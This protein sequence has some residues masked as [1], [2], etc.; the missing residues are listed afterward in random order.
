MR[1][2]IAGSPFRHNERSFVDRLTILM[3][4]TSLVWMVSG[5]VIGA[6]MLSDRVV[7]GAWRF[8]MQPTHGHMLF[9]GWFVQFVIGIAYWLLPRKRTPELP[10]GYNETPALVGV[11][12]LNAGL[13][14]R[15]VGEPMDRIRGE[16]EVAMALLVLSSVL[17]LGA[18]LIFVWQMWPRIYGRDKMGD[19]RMKKTVEKIAKTQS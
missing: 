6:L 2:R 12:V 16:D 9:V 8:W 15:V 1:V 17:Q 3:V 11:A 10:I 18:I 4:K 14:L 13:L 7:P 5:F 19:A